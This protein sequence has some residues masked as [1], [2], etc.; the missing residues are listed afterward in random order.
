ME[1]ERTVTAKK[2]QYSLYRS[3]NSSLFYFTLYRNTLSKRIMDLSYIAN[4]TW[5]DDVDIS[6]C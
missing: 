2:E 1:Y 4:S 6:A 5:S 3:F